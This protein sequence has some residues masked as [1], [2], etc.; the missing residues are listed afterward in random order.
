MKSLSV[1]LGVILIGLAIFAYA[2][3]CKGQCAWVL[4]IRYEK[5]MIEEGK[6]PVQKVDWELISAVPKYEQCMLMQKELYE[7]Q[8]KF[9]ESGG[10]IKVEG[11]PFNLITLTFQE[12]LPW[13]IKLNCFPDT[14]DPRK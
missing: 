4:W 14:I 5:L 10:K 6:A 8:K 11:V 2:E 1:K 12:G 9:W 3:P 7:K 13:F